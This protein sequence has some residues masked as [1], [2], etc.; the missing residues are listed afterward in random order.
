[1]GILESSKHLFQRFA[2]FQEVCLRVCKPSLPMFKYREVSVPSG[3]S[4]LPLPWNLRLTDLILAL[5][6]T[7][8][9]NFP[10]RRALEFAP[11]GEL[12]VVPSWSSPFKYMTGSAKLI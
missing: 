12:L 10:L 6:V 11:E 2:S 8:K 4:V 5:F 3:H 7:R 9:I 1:M